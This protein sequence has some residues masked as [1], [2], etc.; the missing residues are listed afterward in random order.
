[1]WAVALSGIAALALH[2]SSERFGRVAL[3]GFIA[4]KLLLL[5][6]AVIAIP[7]PPIDVWQLQQYACD[8]L[9]H[10]KNP[11]TTAIPSIYAAGAAPFGEQNFYPYPPL[12]L[13]L[14]LPARALLGDYR[15]GLVAS[16]GGALVLLRAAGRRLGVDR[17]DL[18]LLS[19][20]LLLHPRLDRLIIHGWTEP[21]AILAIALFVYLYARAPGSAL[22]AI[23]L[24]A[25]PLIK[26]YFA[27]PVLLYLIMLR[28]RLRSLAIAGG[29]A[30]LA[31]APLLLWNFH[32]TVE[33]GLLFFVQRVAFRADSLSVAA[34]LARWP[35]WRPGVWT[36]LGAGLV[37]G[38]AAFALLR[39]GLPRYLLAAA[40]ALFAA[41]LLA[42]QAFLNYYFSVGGLLLWGA[43]AFSQRV[44]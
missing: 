4:A 19:F 38:A 39:R 33:H 26:Q 44:D 28:P 36:A 13:L 43:L 22:E 41:I 27:V 24:I 3:W 14:S 21:Y 20:A 10:G 18:D 1:V 25:L 8:Y 40:L 9:L 6:G 2:A 42:P 16:I 29:A 31:L 35:G 30:A 17:R 7:R 32:A 23:T 37:A 11:Y 5:A 34:A 12:N 15:Y